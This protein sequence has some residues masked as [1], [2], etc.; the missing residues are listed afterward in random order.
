MGWPDQ[1][2]PYEFTIEH[3]PGSKIV[4]VD[5]ML[6]EPQ[7]EATTISTYDEQ[8]IAVKLVGNQT[9]GK[10]PKNTAFAERHETFCLNT[11]TLNTG[12]K[13]CSE[14]RLRNRRIL[15]AVIMTE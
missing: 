13:I 7:E 9:K 10:N 12:D 8:F 3:L 1:L 6:R 11:N 14:F 4:F 5:C 15:K 2:I